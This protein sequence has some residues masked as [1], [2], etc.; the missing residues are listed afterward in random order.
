MATLDDLLGLLH[1]TPDDGHRHIRIIDPEIC[2]NCRNQPCLTLCPSGVF[3]AG[4]NT[5]QPVAVFYRQCLECGSCR[6]ICTNIDF[7][8][9][10][11]GYGVEFCED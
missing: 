4:K 5:G 2:R 6:L 7:S 9:P 3:T 8:Y 11:S 10:Q 1:F